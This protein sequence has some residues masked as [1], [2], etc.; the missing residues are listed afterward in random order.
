M[1]TSHVDRGSAVRVT[2]LYPVGWGVL[3]LDLR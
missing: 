3:V 1:I 2:L